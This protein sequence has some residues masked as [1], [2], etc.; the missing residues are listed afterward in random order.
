[1]LSRFMIIS[2][3]TTFSLEKPNQDW[4]KGRL[5]KDFLKKKDINTVNSCLAQHSADDD[6]GEISGKQENN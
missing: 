6:Y 4:W 3:L 5:L 1:M 2:F